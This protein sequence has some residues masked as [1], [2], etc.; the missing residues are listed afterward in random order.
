MLKKSSLAIFAIAMLL[1]VIPSAYSIDNSKVRY[2]SVIEVTETSLN[3]ALSSLENQDFDSTKNFIE[4]GSTH[5][6]KNLEKLRAVDPELTD[7]VHISLLDLQTRQLTPENLSTV[8]SEITRIVEIFETIPEDEEYNPNVTVALLIIVDEQYAIF[9][10]EGSEFSYQ[11]AVGFMERANQIFYSGTDYNE[12]QKV[13]LQ[14]FFNDMFEMVK[15]KDPYASIASTNIWVQRD[16]LGTDVVG[17]IGTDSSS[18]YIVIKELYAE[19]MIELDNGDYKKAEQLGIEAYLE[20]FEYLEPEIEVADAELLYQLE[21]DMREE[22]RTMIKNYE[23]PDVIKSFLTDSIIPRLDT[24]EAKVAELRASG[25]VIAEVFANKETKPMGSA[26]EGEKQNVRDEIDV[27]REQLMA[28]EIF[29]E[30]GD[31]QAAYASARSAYLDSYEYVEIPLRAIA[32]DFTFE[33]EYQFA[34]LRNQ[35]N[36][37]APIED[38]STTIISL[39]R[40]L[41]ESER[42]VSGTGTIAPMIAFISSFSIIF[43][44]GLEAVLILGAI[45]TYLEASRNHKFKKYV[46]YG[47]GL[48]IGATAVTWVIASYI[49]EISGANRELIEAIA[50]LS[51][52]AVLFYVSFWILNKIEHKRWMEFVKAKVFQASAAG[53]TS[54]FIMLSFF[55]VYREGFETVLFYQAMFSFAKYMEFYVGLGFILGIV[56]LLGIY[57][58]FRKLGKR[59]P[60]RALF[61]LT[62]GIGAYLSIAFLG[63]A[64]REFQVLDYIPYTSML[65]TIPR[66]DIN[67]ATMTGIYPTLETT[68]G[69]IVLLAV[70]LV[71]S[72]YVLVLRPKRQKALA[73]MRKSRAQVDEQQTN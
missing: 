68:V 47:I 54:V 59:L 35:I 41:D 10:S 2:Y 60:L 14:S 26:S 21:W 43:R 34:T 67:V 56:S 8:S 3:L 25:V 16:L 37:G 29:Y 64:I 31:T 12:R 4:F 30:L 51:A 48:A 40:S 53:G 61:G 39:E 6:S 11:I 57:F 62:M 15:N 20:N 38:I 72:L 13:E 7:E 44:E 9:E 5:F 1:F 69:Q 58:G 45:I 22:L 19:L 66:L 23:D 42:L 49:I 65:G 33:V 63:N 27:I 52:T 55:T 46:H 73:S 32:P 17:T 18:F 71:A 24:A 28:T 70:Y 36:D 50:A